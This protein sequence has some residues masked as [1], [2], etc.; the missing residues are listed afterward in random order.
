MGKKKRTQASGAVEKHG[1]HWV[2]VAALVSQIERINSVV[3]DGLSFESYQWE[4]GVNGKKKDAKLV[5][6]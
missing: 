6:R 3:N 1:K 2:A 4:Q 5:K